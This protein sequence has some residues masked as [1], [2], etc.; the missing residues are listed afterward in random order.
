MMFWFNSVTC[1]SYLDDMQ[2]KTMSPLAILY[3]DTSVL[4]NHHASLVSKLVG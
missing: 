3:N 1:I 2:T 4:E